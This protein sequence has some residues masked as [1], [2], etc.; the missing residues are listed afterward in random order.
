MIHG[1][2]RGRREDSLGAHG[3]LGSSNPRPRRRSIRD[4]LEE[5][6]GLHLERGAQPV[7]RVGREAAKG[8]LGIGEAIGCRH[9]QA[10]LA[11]QPVRRPT[12][13]LEHVSEMKQNHEAMVR[14]PLIIRGVLNFDNSNAWC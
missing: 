9:R 3:S 10:G 8:Y 2:R 5:L 1:E 4:P 7:E 11:R 12:L 14:V 13:S 6:T